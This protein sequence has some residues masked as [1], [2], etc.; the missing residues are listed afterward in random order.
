MKRKFIFLDV[1]NSMAMQYIMG[2][3][4]N[5]DDVIYLRVF[6]H[7]KTALD[8]FLNQLVLL[9]TRDKRYSKIFLILYYYAYFDF[10]L[11]I[12]IQR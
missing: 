1:Q 10:N 8:R 11:F 2:D 5:R 4:R 12:L 9:Y 3:I 6:K 7:N